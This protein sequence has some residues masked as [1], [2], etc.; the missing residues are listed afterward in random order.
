MIELEQF[1]DGIGFGVYDAIARFQEQASHPF[2]GDQWALSSSSREC[3][4]RARVQ[5][6][7][8]WPF[9]SKRACLS[10]WASAREG[11]EGDVARHVDLV[12][13]R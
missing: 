13:S 11:G 10:R 7:D 3:R 8:C 6:A 12:G 9:I 2:Y 5:S 4:D 1:A